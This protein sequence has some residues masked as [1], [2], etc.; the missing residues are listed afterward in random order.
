MLDFHIG[1]LLGFVVS[2]LVGGVLMFDYILARLGEASTWRGI[3][4]FLTASGVVFQPEQAEAII[5][6][7]L[8]FIGVFGVFTKDKK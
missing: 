7:G 6:A 8:A 2:A 4:A 3:V 5:A 1:W